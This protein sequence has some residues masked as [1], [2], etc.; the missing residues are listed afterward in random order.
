MPT[1]YFYHCL[2]VSKAG[3]YPS[4]APYGIQSKGRLLGLFANIRLEWKWV[5]VTN[6]TAYNTAEVKAT[7]QYFIV[8]A[9]TCQCYK[10]FLFI[11]HAKAK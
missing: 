11:A 8:Q 2:A 10:T 6:A 7:L 1:R 4:E 3:T 9:S 5:A